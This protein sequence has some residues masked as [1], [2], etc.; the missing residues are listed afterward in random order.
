[1]KRTLILSSVILLFAFSQLA[2]QATVV[3]QRLVPVGKGNAEKIIQ[4]GQDR[5]L[6]IGKVKKFA[7]ALLTD[8]FGNQITFRSFR[9]TVGGRRS[10]FTDVA[11]TTTGYVFAGD[12]DACMGTS[13]TTRKVLICETD[14]NFNVIRQ[15]KLAPPAHP[16]KQYQNWGY[17]YL[18][19]DGDN[20]VMLSQ[21]VY[22][23]DATDTLRSDFALTQFRIRNNQHELNYHRAYHFHPMNNIADIRVTPDA[24]YVLN[25]TASKVEIGSDTASL[26]RYEKNGEMRNEFQFRGVPRV[27]QPLGTDWVIGGSVTNNIFDGP[28]AQLYRVDGDNGEVKSQFA[29]GGSKMDAIIDLKVLPNNSI[30]ALTAENC[31]YPD[32]NTLKDFSGVFAFPETWPQ[33]KVGRVLRLSAG[34]MQEVS[35]PVVFQNPSGKDLILRSIV[36]LNTDGSLFVSC[37]QF[38]R[39]PLFYSVAP[40]NLT[41]GPDATV[42][43]DEAEKPDT[44]RQASTS[45]FISKLWPNPVKAGET[46]TLASEQF[47]DKQEVSIE[48][49]DRSGRL[50]SQQKGNSTEIELLAPD[51]AG[52]YFLRAT[53]GAKVLIGRT[54]MVM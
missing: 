37:G 24:Y 11:E 33:P 17:Q 39:Q 34:S 19:P 43:P 54:F 29:F 12:C 30:L 7:Y 47:T 4:I 28:Q 32:V 40:V 45:S 44:K 36:P 27:L 50:I 49:L 31:A 15:T 23:S 20:F 46:F 3:T 53:S 41:A 35:P 18:R 10:E 48:I 6:T 2:A 13:D 9:L 25:W 22:K 42:L 51:R 38:N 26:Y 52:M 8:R 21:L 14:K 5:F 1:M 16:T